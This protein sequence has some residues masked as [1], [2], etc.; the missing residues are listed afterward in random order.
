MTRWIHQLGENIFTS[1]YRLHEPNLDLISYPYCSMRL[2]DDTSWISPYVL[3]RR[4]WDKVILTHRSWFTNA[5]RRYSKACTRMAIYLSPFQPIQFSTGVRLCFSGNLFAWGTD[6]L[7]QTKS[8]IICKFSAFP[9]TRVLVVLN[10]ILESQYMEYLYKWFLR[11]LAVDHGFDLT[12][13]N[14]EKGV[15]YPA[16]PTSHLDAMHVW[17]SL[18]RN[19]KGSSSIVDGRHLIE[20]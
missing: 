11:R 6:R 16:F 12:P 8:L 15:L 17:S 14:K 2:L 1:K 9:W 13:A 5:I 3:A 19:S 4:V 20:R 10:R 7:L 18:L